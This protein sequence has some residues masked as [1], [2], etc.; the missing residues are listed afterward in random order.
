MQLT[1]FRYIFALENGNES[2]QRYENESETEIETENKTAKTME[3][4]TRMIPTTIPT[5]EEVKWAV[6]RKF[7]ASGADTVKRYVDFI[8]C[9]PMEKWDV[10]AK[11]ALSLR[12]GFPLP[13]MD[14]LISF[15]D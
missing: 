4:E 15:L 7:G 6:F 8:T 11:V 9:A 12:E 1:I 5:L 13:E 2:A 10:R 14:R 3:K